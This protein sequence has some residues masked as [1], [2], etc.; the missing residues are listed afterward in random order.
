M[1]SL[2]IPPKPVIIT[3]N[4]QKVTALNNDS[5]A[6]HIETNEYSVRSLVPDDVNATFLS[7]FNTKE[8]L[9]GLNIASPNFTL[10][11]LKN[12][13]AQ[14][15]NADNYFLGIFTG[16]ELIGFYSIDV[17]KS[18]QTA[19]ISTGIGNKNY[20]GKGVLWATIDAVIDYFY[21][22]RNIEKFTA[23]VI[24]R[25]FGML[26]NFKNNPRFELE[27]YLKRECVGLDGKRVDILIFSSFKTEKDGVSPH[28]VKNPT[29]IQDIS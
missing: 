22:N 21:A 6:I 4:G 19:G 29:H 27:A 18:H 23:R 10:E 17:N 24:A 15:N 25:N 2:K 5:R 16:A 7:W 1:V 3:L 20:V 26:F 8:I 11:R 12:F 9:E 14:F 13:I 28:R